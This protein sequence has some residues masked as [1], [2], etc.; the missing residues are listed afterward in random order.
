MTV[1]AVTDR[2]P[3]ICVCFD[4]RRS[5]ILAE[6]QRPGATFS[7]LVDETGVGRKCTACRMDLEMLLGQPLEFQPSME[8]SDLVGPGLGHSMSDNR[9]CGFFVCTDE[10]DT[11][12]CVS[13][14]ALP[15]DKNLQLSTFD[16]VCDI[17]S[18]QGERLA[19]RR[20]RLEPHGDLLVSM[21]EL[22]GAI[23]Y[24]WFILNLIPRSAGLIGNTRPQVLLV[25]NGWAASYHAQLVSW[26]SKVRSVM[27]GA[28][29][30]K[31]S[32][33]FPVLNME[34]K[35]AALTVD[36][37]KDG[38][39]VGSRQTMVAADSLAVLDVDALFAAEI[40]RYPDTLFVAVLHSDRPTRRY[41]AIKHR[42][43]AMSID[44]FPN[45]R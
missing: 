9:N 31:T 2:D 24:G 33:L 13:N 5:D 3:V 19:T 34:L 38:G 30:G 37:Y 45:T 29:D 35:D 22:V 41:I 11:V 8:R 10:I 7:K 40:E 23:G 18:Q 28:R 14:H 39:L 16:Y 32:A 4:K 36:L 44:H 25:G 43:G 15:T 42:N 20:G 17:R 27:V 21:R 1:S 26:A 6:M 12:L